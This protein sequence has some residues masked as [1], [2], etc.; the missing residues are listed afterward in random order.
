[1]FGLFE[2]DKLNGF[3]LDISDASIKVMQLAASSAGPVA[4]AYGSDRLPPQIIANHSIVNAQKLSGYIRKLV[5]A[6]KIESKFVV[7]S[8]PEAKSF[9]RQIK[10]PKMEVDQIQTAVPFEFE[11]NIPIPIDQVYFDWQIVTESSDGFELLVTASPKDYIDSLIEVLSSIKLQ[12]LAFELES[13]ATARALLGPENVNQAN[14]IIDISELQ[15]SFLLVEKNN[16]QYTSSVP[17]GGA[18]FTE[19]IARN[20]TISLEE[21][22]KAKREQ[23]LV[24]DSKKRNIRQ[25]IL[26]ILDNIVDEI[27]NVVRFYDEHYKNHMPLKQIIVCGGGAKLLGLTDYVSARLNLSSAHPTSNVALG[28]SLRLLAKNSTNAKIDGLSYSTA[29]GLAMR[30]IGFKIDW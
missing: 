21:A 28:D 2:K 14:L 16:L 17:I 26:P 4:R 25:A 9:V 24:A 5:D 30:G 22:E 1:M 29:I 15:T 19:S 8:I 6:A 3:G 27:R 11:Q 7:V 20:L 10:L 13:Q 18:S 12:A 23:G